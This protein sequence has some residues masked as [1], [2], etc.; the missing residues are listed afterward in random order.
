MTKK[1]LPAQRYDI[2]LT[3]FEKEVA[4]RQ[5]EIAEM[6]CLMRPYEI[7]RKALE[8]VK[9]PNETRL[10]LSKGTVEAT[11]TPKENDHRNSFDEL[12]KLIGSELK[13]ANLH[14]S[15]EHAYS[16]SYDIFFRW[17]LSEIRGLKTPATINIRIDVPY[18]GT[19]YIKVVRTKRP[20][21]YDDITTTITW[22]EAKT[23][24]QE[25]T[26]QYE[27]HFRNYP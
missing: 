7:V 11:I 13:L 27:S 19:K 25:E 2:F 15:G 24:T 14:P 9:L 23:K 21:T 8:A 17:R 12:L 1:N 3:A 6:D 26:P 4:K 16:V 22:L 18:D 10:T 20:T 5:A